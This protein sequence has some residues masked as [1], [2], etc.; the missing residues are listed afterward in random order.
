MQKGIRRQ[1]AVLDSVSFEAEKG[2]LITLFGPNG[3]GKS[4]LFRIISGLEDAHT[5][6]VRI[7]GTPPAR[8]RIG[9]VFQ[10][11]RSSMLPWR[12]VVDNVALALEARGNMKH[13]AIGKTALGY[14]RQVKMEEYADRRFWELS[15]GQSQ[16]VAIARAL[17]YSPDVFLLD[18]PFSALDFEITLQM[19]LLFLDVWSKNKITTLFISH[20]IEE[21]VFLA[22]RVIVLSPRPGRIQEIIPVPLSRPRHPSMLTTP[23]FFTTRNN[24]LAAFRRGLQTSYGS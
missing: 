1:N 17:A 20:Q 11:Y 19:M 10:D 22:D 15:G 3:S 23:E 7:G 24:V 18:E 4:T 6:E 13:T 16:S 5:G 12:S 14:L 8:A 9:F 2:E 21:A